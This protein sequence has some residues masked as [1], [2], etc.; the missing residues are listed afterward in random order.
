MRQPI[1]LRPV[2]NAN[3]EYDPDGGSGDGALRT[4]IDSSF[5]L[6]AHLDLDQGLNHAGV[7]FGQ[8]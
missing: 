1:Y 5:S 6:L 2:G 8:V 4:G 3:R 7:L